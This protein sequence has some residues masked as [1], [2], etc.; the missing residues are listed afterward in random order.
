MQVLCSFTTFL[1]SGIMSKLRIGT[2]LLALS[3]F[4]SISIHLITPSWQLDQSWMAQTHPS[5]KT[6]DLHWGVYTQSTLLLKKI[7][8]SKIKI[9]RQVE[10]LKNKIWSGDSY[11]WSVNSTDRWERSWWQTSTQPS[12]HTACKTMPATKKSVLCS[13]LQVPKASVNSFSFLV[14]KWC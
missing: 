2:R 6:S 5:T 9:P 7:F 1:L 4:Q 8:I 10:H 13:H 12:L 3:L 11:N 14:L